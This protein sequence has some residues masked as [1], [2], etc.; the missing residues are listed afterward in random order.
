MSQNVAMVDVLAKGWEVSANTSQISVEYT[1]FT[2][3]CTIEAPTNNKQ[4]PKA[5]SE[6]KY[7]QNLLLLKFLEFFIVN[8]NYILLNCTANW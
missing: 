1:V 5:N 8:S 7:K 2:P 6:I 4:T 3:I